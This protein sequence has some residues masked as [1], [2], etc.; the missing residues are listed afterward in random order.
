MPIE[1]AKA[2]PIIDHVTIARVCHE[3]NRAF[4]E[5]H[6]NKSQPSWN[7]APEWQRRSAVNGVLFHLNNPTRSPE[8][9]HNN[10][11]RE[12][13]DDGWTYGPKKDP[14]K[15][16]HPCIQPYD[17]LPLIQRKKDSL[18]IAIVHALA[19]EE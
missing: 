16:T 18:F 17:E 3:A 2:I 14:E 8:D 15:K 10:W 11:M 5:S 4:C 9:S 6:G 19:K 1:A 13:I 7:N 12:K